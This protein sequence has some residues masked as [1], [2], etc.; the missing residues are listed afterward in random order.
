MKAHELVEKAIFPHC[1]ASILNKFFYSFQLLK[2]ILVE[3]WKH[4]IRELYLQ[5]LKLK[6]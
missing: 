1:V 5:K 6:N 3:K 4:L 2:K